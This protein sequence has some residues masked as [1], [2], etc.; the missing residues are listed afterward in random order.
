M[1]TREIPSQLGELNVILETC[2]RS[3]DISPILHPL[4]QIQKVILAC[5]NGC[6]EKQEDLFVRIPEIIGQFYREHAPHE[7]HNIHARAKKNWC[8]FSTANASEHHALIQLNFIY[9]ELI[10]LLSQMKE[11]EFQRHD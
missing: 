6:T 2:L 5:T 8:R 1:N 9:I 4:S 7:N 11:G 3:Q 10:I